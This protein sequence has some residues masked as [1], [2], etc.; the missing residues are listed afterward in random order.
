MSKR[1]NKK[2]REKKKRKARNRNKTEILQRNAIVRKNVIK[3]D[4]PMLHTPTLEVRDKDHL[5]QINKEI[6]FDLIKKLKRT[7][8]AFK[9]GA[10]L[11]ANQIGQPYNVAVVR[12]D[13]KS[14]NVFAIINPKII[15]HS[16]ETE[17]A[18]EGCLSFPDYYTPIER[19]HCI[20]VEYL[21][22]NFEKQT[23]HYHGYQARVICHEIDHLKGSPSLKWYYR[24]QKNKAR[25]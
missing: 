5:E 19:Y 10:G 15:E 2:L 11:S 12:F 3:F 7:V 24:E 13:T 25:K 22:E 18:V 9:N 21:D 23:V 20:T 4:A 1:V 17:R 14:D 16:Q 8:I 6:G